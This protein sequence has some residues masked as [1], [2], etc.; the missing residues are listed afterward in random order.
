MQ[1]RHEMV[2]RNIEL[3]SKE[4]CQ[5]VIVLS[6]PEDTAFLSSL[7]RSDL[8]YT[9]AKNE[10]LGHKFQQGVN[11]CRMLK[12]D[13]LIITG[14][15]DILS[16]GFIEKATEHCAHGIDFLCLNHWFIHHPTTGKDYKLRYRMT[17][18]LGG[19]RAFSKAYLDR[20]DWKLFDTSMNRRT[21][22]FAWEDARYQDN[23]MFNPPDMNI[24]SIKGNW[25][26]LNNLDAILK[27]DSITWDYEKEIDKHFNFDRPI[28]EIFKGL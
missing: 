2:R 1:G 13:P 9:I 27:A 11:C 24:L 6:D 10:P 25:S 12:A 22:D 7:G 16:D 21:D 19:G 4:K 17:F 20:H 28:K 8:Y 5:I 3:L 23:I 18:P 26:T 15:D 14:S